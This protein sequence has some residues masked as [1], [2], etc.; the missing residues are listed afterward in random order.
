MT[1]EGAGGTGD[2][3]GGPEGEAVGTRGMVGR[4]VRLGMAVAGAVADGGNV[5]VEEM[6]GEAGM[7][8][9]VKKGVAGAG[10]GRGAQAA[11][12]SSTGSR[13]R[14]FT[15]RWGGPGR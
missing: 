15:W 5:G 2:W 9:V 3:P 10:V 1:G 6:V 14:G 7:P 11:T 4:G 13:R 12:S 8:V